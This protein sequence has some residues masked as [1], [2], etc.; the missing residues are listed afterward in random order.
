VKPRLKVLGKEE[1][2]TIYTTALYLL[3]KVGVN[4]EDE[5]IIKL[6]ANN[7]CDVDSNRIVYF[8]E[9]LVRDCLNSTPKE[10]TLCGRNPSCDM[11]VGRQKYPYIIPLVSYNYFDCVSNT[12]RTPTKD[13]VARFVRLCDHLS[14]VNGVWMLSM[15][16][17]FED[18]YMFGDFILGIRNTTKPVCVIN[19]EPKSVEPTYQ[20]AVEMA[21]GEDEL[22]R[23]PLLTV[24]YCCI[25]PLIWNKEG[26]AMLKATARWGIIPAISTEA[27]MG[28]TG[29]VTVA[30]DIA[31]K[32]AE[33]LSGAVVLQ[34]LNRGMPIIWVD[35]HETFD[36]KTGAVNFASHGNFLYACA[37]GQIEEYLGIPIVTPVI[38][39]S[40][41]LDLQESYELGFL[42]LT[43]M[44][45]GSRLVVTHG[46]DSSRAFN[47]ELLLLLDDMVTATQRILDGIEVNSDTL[48]VE[49]IEKVC[50]KIDGKRRVGHFLDQ[51]HTLN[52]Y[53]KEHRPRKDGIFEKH[54]REKWMELGSK[55]FTQRAHE[56]V[57]EILS[58]HKP[59]PLPREVEQKIAE[60]Q[61]KYQIKV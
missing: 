28:D 46:L 47:N 25:S 40:K 54:R 58:T 34:L 4:I 12:Y 36:Q 17:E 14:T 51:R 37:I 39:D 3:K 20:L 22:K 44:L 5:G 41:L 26:C 21:G 42:L 56:K 31:Q 15:I 38:P 52:W 45:G 55:S 61:K 6:L 18:M 30:G 7:G 2:D 35:V 1:L 11:Q 49:V 24:N 33:F 53:A 59:E 32:M 13:D 50:R 8:P 23:R 9:W 48:A 10:V 19:F 60:L 43:Q 27:P 29:P 16:P 57:E